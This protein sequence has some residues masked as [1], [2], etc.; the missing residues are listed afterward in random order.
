MP[1][2]PPR[3]CVRF[4]GDHMEQVSVSANLVYNNTA[5]TQTATVRLPY[6]PTGYEASEHGRAI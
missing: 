4:L 2:P 6:A 5:E 3:T 1:N